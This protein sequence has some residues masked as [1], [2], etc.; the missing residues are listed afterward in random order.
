MPL[1]AE[2][3]RFFGEA[4][5]PEH[6]AS[7]DAVVAAMDELGID[8]GL[9]TVGMFGSE[10]VGDRRRVSDPVED[11]IAACERFPDRFRASPMV[12]SIPS[13]RTVCRRIEELASH[14]LVVMMRI[15][16]L[17]IQEPLNSRI[18]Y[19]IYERC[20]G[21]GLAVSINIGV[22]GPKVRAACQQPIFL[23]DVLIDF[24]DLIVVGAHMGHPWEDLLIRLM[25]KYE[26][27]YLCNSA[28]LAKYIEPSVVR[29]MNSS[30][31]R[32]KLM[33]ASDFPLLPFG[34]A[35]DSARALPLSS[36]AMEAYLG[37]NCKRALGWKELP[38]G[39]DA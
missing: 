14:P 24:P 4:P 12:D 6:T 31:G 28:Y 2:T 20:E 17:L 13:I 9:A 11:L 23:D 3:V 10:L 33:F 35:I 26:N 1:I 16:P 8:Q 37:G 34:K 32:D 15:V 39:R 30:R 38:S 19:P 5:P 7:V 18:F 29:F 25:M 22:P 27:L 21:L 36:D